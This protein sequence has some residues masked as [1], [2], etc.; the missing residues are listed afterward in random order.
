MKTERGMENE[1]IGNKTGRENFTFVSVM[2]FYL[3]LFLFLFYEVKPYFYFLYFGP[4][5]MTSN[6]ICN[7]S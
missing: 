4:I 6:L 5:L 2:I 1:K 3:I 7:V